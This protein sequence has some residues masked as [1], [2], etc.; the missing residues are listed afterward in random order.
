M[1]GLDGHVLQSRP[2]PHLPVK[3]INS[4][5]LFVINQRKG[6]NQMSKKCDECGGDGICKNE[7]HVQPE[8]GLLDSMYKGMGSLI[9]KCPACGSSNA[10]MGGKC[11]ACGGTG[12]A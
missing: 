7:F 4:H 11:S 5:L 2:A 12:E 1:S 8:D 9:S 10:E 3:E 6:A